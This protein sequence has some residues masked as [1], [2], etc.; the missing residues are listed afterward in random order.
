MTYN[1]GRLADDGAI[2]GLLG[3]LL[4]AVVAIGCSGGGDS[5]P[6]APESR[7]FVLSRQR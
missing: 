6:T 7:E 5:D 2:L 1:I 4:L 3:V